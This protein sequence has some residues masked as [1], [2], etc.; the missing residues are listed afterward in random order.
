MPSP[1]DV[2]AIL[3]FYADNQ[4][5]FKATDPPRPPPFYTEDYWSKRVR[6]MATDYVQDKSAGFFLFASSDDRAV[7]GSINLSNV[8]RGAFQACHLGYA[9][10]EREQGK[11]LMTEAL[12]MALRFAW[13]KLKLHRVMANYLPHNER[14]ARVLKKLGFVVEGYARDY[15][16]ID[17]KW[18]DHVLTALTNERWEGPP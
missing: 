6:T 3:R 5:F 8:V 4:A 15:L 14:S 18:Q 17:G 1:S 12:T 11:G 2:P 13:E 10:A 9:I 7:I 16:F